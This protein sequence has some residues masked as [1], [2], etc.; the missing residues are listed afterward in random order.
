MEFKLLVVDD[1]RETT[2]SLA[3]FLLNQG[4]KLLLAGSGDEAVAILEREPMDLVVLDLHMPGLAGEDVIRH[5]KAKHPATRVVVVTGY[6]ERA[7]GARALGCDALLTKPFAMTELTRILQTLLAQKDEDELRDAF[8]SH[9]A[10]GAAPGE[11]VA[12]LLFLEPNPV[13]SDVL[14]EFFSNA[15]RAEGRYQVYM[16][17]TLDRA[18]GLMIGVHPD[19]ALLDLMRFPHPEEAVKALHA[20]EFQPKDYIFCLHSRL[21]EDERFLESLPSKRWDGNPLQEQGLKELAQL[22]HRTALEHALVK[23]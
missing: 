4:Y 6:P 20:C 10:T 17:D 16:A 7:P 8:L 22:V 23:R 14:A 18:L 2:A 11:P 19:I 21:P 13:L 15:A 1:E 12:Q 5:I 3:E 9:K